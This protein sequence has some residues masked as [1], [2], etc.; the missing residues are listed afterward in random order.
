MQEAVPEGEGAMAAILGL[1][2]TQVAEACA[3]AAQGGVV[4][5]VNFNAPGQV[6]IAGQRTAV[7]RATDVAKKLGAKRAVLLPVSVPSH[8]ALMEDAAQ[9]LRTRLET[10]H[11][12]SPRIPVVN[13]VDVAAP[14]KPAAIR[15]ALVRQLHSPV[16]W[17]ECVR[18]I[19]NRGTLIVLEVGP[20]KVLAGLCKRIEKGVET[21]AV[22]DPHGLRQA[23]DLNA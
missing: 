20:G 7:N 1:D 22:F 12:T 21:R 13:N 14:H 6:V 11:I 10:V 15:D 3:S 18:N 23:L 17:V 19:V 4:T 5:A 8:C 16:R 9:Q 2:N